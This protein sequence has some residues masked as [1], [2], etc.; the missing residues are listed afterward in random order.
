MRIDFCIGHIDVSTD[1]AFTQTCLHD[2]A[3]DFFA[4]LAPA[5]AI[6]FSQT[7]EF[8][9]RQG[10]FIGDTLQCFVE[11]AVVDLDAG[12]LGFLNLDQVEDHPIQQL[13]PEQIDRR[14]LGAL[15]L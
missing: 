7:P 4:E 8:S 9:H 2:L 5:N 6:R 15:F 11:G 1:F 13:F 10:V 3:A 12:F 14:Q